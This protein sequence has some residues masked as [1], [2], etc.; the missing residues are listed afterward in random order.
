[1][2]RSSSCCL[3]VSISAYLA[4]EDADFKQIM[5]RLTVLAVFHKGASE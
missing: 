1:M 5:N 3:R 2:K 4:P